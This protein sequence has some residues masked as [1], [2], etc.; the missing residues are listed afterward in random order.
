MTYLRRRDY[1]RLG[2]ALRH[3]KGPWGP[4]TRPGKLSGANGRDRR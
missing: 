3:A 2:V 4:C 1:A